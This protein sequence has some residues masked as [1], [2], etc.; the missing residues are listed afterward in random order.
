MYL[1]TDN[2][3][4][5][6]ICNAR[7]EGRL[8]TT[9]IARTHSISG[10]ITGLPWDYTLHTQGS[11]EP[12]DVIRSCLCSRCQWRIFARRMLWCLLCVITASAAAA[13]IVPQ[14]IGTANTQSAH[15]LQI[16][17]SI[18]AGLLV[19]FILALTES[20]VSKHT[21]CI[22]ALQSMYARDLGTHYG[23][24]NICKHGKVGLVNGAINILTEEEWNAMNRRSSGSGK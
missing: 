14:Y 15:E 21:A 16:A 4:I 10:S 11:L 12:I 20:L 7:G 2:S 13:L 6:T 1:E 9:I 17:S 23:S 24:N 18:F 5:C 8:F 22:Y 3:V 19:F